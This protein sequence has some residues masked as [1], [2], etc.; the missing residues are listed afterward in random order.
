[1]DFRGAPYDACVVVREGRGAEPELRGGGNV[2]MAVR[3]MKERAAFLTAYR[4][5]FTKMRNAVRDVLFP[6]GTWR[7]FRELGV[8]VVSTT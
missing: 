2:E 1:M 4:E 3:A 7:L 8:N 5:A 6:V